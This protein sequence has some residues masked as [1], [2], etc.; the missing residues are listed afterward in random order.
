MMLM[1]NDQANRIGIGVNNAKRNSNNRREPGI[2]RS[3]CF[4]ARAMP[5]V[6]DFI[7]YLRYRTEVAPSAYAHLTAM[8]LAQSDVVGLWADRTDIANSLYYARQLRGKAERF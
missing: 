2:E 4:A 6:L 3:A 5:A 7:G 8:D 1:T